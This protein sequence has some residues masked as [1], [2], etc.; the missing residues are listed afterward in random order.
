M[1]PPPISHSRDMA[2][3][4]GA[5][6]AGAL[7]PHPLSPPDASPS[8]LLDPR[9]VSAAADHALPRSAT[10]LAPSRLGRPSA[11]RP[12]GVATDL[13]VRAVRPLV[14]PLPSP[15]EASPSHECDMRT[16]SAVNDRAPPSLGSSDGPLVNGPW[17]RVSADSTA[18]ISDFY[19]ACAFVPTPSHAPTPSPLRECNP[20]TLST[21]EDRARAD[22]R[23][24]GWRSRGWPPSREPVDDVSANLQRKRGLCTSRA[25]CVNSQRLQAVHR[26]QRKKGGEPTARLPTARLR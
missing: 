19:A 6:R 16:A 21:L 26:R 14:H 10:R 7:V 25:R 22:T 20:Q 15:P 13:G 2:A 8:R 24:L 5:R 11:V 23:T 1:D 4:L 18:S 3:D 17:L 9:T 12:S